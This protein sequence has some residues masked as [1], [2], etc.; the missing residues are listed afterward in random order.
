MPKQPQDHLPKAASE[1]DEKDGDFTFEHGGVTFTSTRNVADVISPGFIRRH[2]RLP[3]IDLYFTMLEEM[4]AANKAALGVIDGMEWADLRAL[5]KRL[6]KHMQ[7]TIG[8]SLG[9]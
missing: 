4:F 8:A 3:E 7:R 6:E 5:T 1:P 9:E 2:R